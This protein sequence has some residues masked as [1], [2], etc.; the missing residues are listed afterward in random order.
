MTDFSLISERIKFLRSLTGLGAKDFC[1]HFNVSISSLSKWEANVNPLSLKNANRLIEIATQNGIKCSLEWL[2]YGKGVEAKLL[3]DEEKKSLA[4]NDDCLIALTRE[5]E[6]FKRIYSNS[7]IL[8]VNDNSMLPQFN[9]GDYVGGI[10]IDLSLVHDNLGIPCII[11]TDDMKKRLR[12]IGC[13]DEEFFLFGTNITFKDAPMFEI[14]PSL[15]KI[16][17]VFW[18]HMTRIHQNSI[19]KNSLQDD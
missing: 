12:C 13:K 19:Q 15:T 11:E 9:I 7:E 10:S 1:A 17:P 18:H 4:G 5:I 2:L 14:R 8:V 3:T 6:S 16:T